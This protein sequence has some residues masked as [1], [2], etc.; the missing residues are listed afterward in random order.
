[1][2]GTPATTAGKSTFAIVVIA[3]GAIALS[4]VLMA[5]LGLAAVGVLFCDAPGSTTTDCVLGGARA[6]FGLAAPR[7][8][9]VGVAL[10]ALGAVL[11]L[12]S[13]RRRSA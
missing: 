13:G 5:T 9:P 6:G 3:L 11:R 7:L 1:M 2:S 8:L 10:I 12:L 4:F